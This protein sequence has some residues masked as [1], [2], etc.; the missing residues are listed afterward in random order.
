MSDAVFDRVLELHKRL[1]QRRIVLHNFGD[2]LMHPGIVDL[3]RRASAQ[4]ELV[5]MSTNGV[6][7]T[8]E[9]AV[10]LKKAG[11]THIVFSRHTSHAEHAAEIAKQLAIPCIVRGDF[12]HDW[13]GTSKRHKTLFDSE[14]STEGE[15]S[16]AFLLQPM[17]VVLWNGDVN[18]CCMDTEGL[19]VVGNVMDP[20][21]LDRNLHP[22]ELCEKCPN[23]FSY[24][25][26]RNINW[27]LKNQ[28]KEEEIAESIV[29]TKKSS[30]ITK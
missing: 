21:I 7:F 22:I 20:D 29:A 2:P 30:L 28:E 5:G 17:A 16:C 12:N 8:Y 14:F 11:I 24:D 18:V 19:G 25:R 15:L 26:E 13:A 23:K 3:V 27:I 9:L 4:V 1:G 10:E 6:T